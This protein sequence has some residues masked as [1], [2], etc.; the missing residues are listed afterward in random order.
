M[1]ASPMGQ[2]GCLGM[3]SNSVDDLPGNQ[4]GAAG[5]QIPG[6]DI[7]PMRSSEYQD[8]LAGN[9]F[10]AIR[11]HTET[12]SGAVRVLTTG[13]HWPARQDVPWRV[14]SVRAAAQSLAVR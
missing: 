1:I 8:M 13:T 12:F 4:A 11:C 2:M 14:K 7:D 6:S 10:L 5:Q 9:R 3:T